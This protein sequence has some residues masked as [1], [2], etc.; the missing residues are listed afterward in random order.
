MAPKD[1]PSFSIEIVSRFDSRTIHSVEIKPLT[2]EQYK[3]L[4]A[5]ISE[6]CGRVADQLEAQTDRPQEPK[7]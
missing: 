5:A 1:N 7:P 3:T 6:T 2:H 4:A